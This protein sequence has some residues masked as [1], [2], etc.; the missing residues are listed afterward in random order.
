MIAGLGTIPI[1]LLKELY[2]Q[3]S[4]VCVLSV[5]GKG[6]STPLTIDAY[7]ENFEGIDSITNF[8]K[9]HGCEE[10]VI[11]GSIGENV[12]TIDKLFSDESGKELLSRVGTHEV[13]GD[14]IISFEVK[15]YFLDQGFKIMLPE[16]I[17]PTLL[18]PIGCLTQR[19]PSQ[20]DMEDIKIGINVN[21][22]LS[23]FDFGQTMIISHKQVI[24]IEGKE[25]TDKTL[26]RI[27]PSWDHESHY[28]GN[29]CSGVMIKLPKMNQIFEIDSPTIGLT[30]IQNA[31]K[32]RL[33]GIAFRAKN[34][35]V[36]D[37]DEC[38]NFA[39]KHDLFLL[40]LE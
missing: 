38:I 3:Q 30:T 7:I 21:K 25:G 10:I 27:V 9:N 18:A 4:P 13:V 14:N 28:H 11:I 2:R 17:V 8:F 23:P 19:E 15:Q 22:A 26:E 16:Q 32:A 37:I 12:I 20:Q 5:M 31:V 33:V 1:L 35:L 29:K 40:G 34:T 24:A 36:V 6:Y 39:N